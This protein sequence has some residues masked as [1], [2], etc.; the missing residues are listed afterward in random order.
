M[1]VLFNGEE[2]WNVSS[3]TRL[4]ASPPPQSDDLQAGD[5]SEIQVL[6]IVGDH[7]PECLTWATLVNVDKRAMRCRYNLS[8]NNLALQVS[9]TYTYFHENGSVAD[10]QR[11][12]LITLAL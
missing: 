9:A 2:W 6:G 3:N 5:Q 1:Q 10:K 4:D 12:P 11:V 8:V 7:A